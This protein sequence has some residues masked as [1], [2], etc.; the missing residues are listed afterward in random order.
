MRQFGHSGFCFQT[1]NS[2]RSELCRQMAQYKSEPPGNTGALV[3]HM[4]TGG[5]SVQK[6]GTPLQ[7]DHTDDP[8][9]ED[10]GH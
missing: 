6:E 10:T 4:Q 2:A 9:Q 8:G 3:F 5:G 7:S 1:Q